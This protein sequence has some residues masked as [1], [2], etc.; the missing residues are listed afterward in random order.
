LNSNNISPVIPL[1]PRW[2]V[3]GGEAGA[4]SSLASSIRAL[5]EQEVKNCANPRTQKLYKKLQAQDLKVLAALLIN[6][7]VDSGQGALDFL[8]PDLARLHPWQLLPDIDKAIAR[9]ELARQRREK[10]FIHGDYDADGIT[11]TALL[12]MALE[13]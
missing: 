6:R 2:N 4:I 3:R 7:G 13:N 8:V 11:A 10:V 12:V 1:R 9:L 5:V